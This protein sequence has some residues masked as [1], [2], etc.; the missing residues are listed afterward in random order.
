MRKKWTYV[1]IVSMMLGVAPVFTGCV[2]TDEPAGITELRGAKAELLRAKAAVEQARVALVQAKADLK[3]AEAE[4]ERANAEWI[5]QLAREQEIKNDFEQAKNDIEL[6]KLQAQL[7]SIQTSIAYWKEEAAV[8]HEK[9]MAVLNEA[10]AKAQYAYEV[11]LKQIEVAKALGLA[12]DE[13][14]LTALETE[15]ENA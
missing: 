3:A 11:A 15:V 9:K 13:V 14:S 10:A 2:D 8:R 6:Q 12:Y 7:D 5:N 4:S 1:A